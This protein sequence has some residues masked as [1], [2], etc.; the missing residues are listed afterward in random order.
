M[1]GRCHRYGAHRD[2]LMARA[3]DLIWS[4][5]TAA[6]RGSAIARRAADSARASISSSDRLDTATSHLPQDNVTE[7]R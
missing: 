6:E 1:W 5:T 7:Q 3:W 2:A 4:A